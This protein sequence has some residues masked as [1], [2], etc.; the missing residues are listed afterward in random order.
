[1]G[2]N[3]TLR[4]WA[5]SLAI[6]GVAAVFAAPPVA[7]EP[8]PTPAASSV[9]P[10]G[11]VQAPLL[12]P[13]KHQRP[14]STH[15][16]QFLGLN[17]AAL[18]KAKLKAAQQTSSPPASPQPASPS[19]NSA[20]LFNGLNAPGL[21]AADQGYQPTPPDSTGAVGPT[22][23][24][25]FVNQLVGVYDRSNLSLLGSTD[26]GSFVAVPSGLATSDPQIQ[27]D[28]QGNRWFYVAVGFTSNLNN[29]YILFGW[30]KTSD[31]SDLAN[32]WC[33][34]GTQTGTNFPDY[35]KL[36][37]DANFVM[38]GV[39]TFDT[40][41][42]DLPF[43]TADV[44]A[45][46]KPPAA[47]S[48]CSTSV[49]TSHFADATHPLK[50]TDGTLAATPV[51]A[52]TVDP[53]ANGYIVSA[54]DPSSGAQSKLM[55][56]HMAAGPALV[57]DGDISVA[58]YTVPPS[59]PQPGTGYLIDS[60]DGRLTQA[61]ANF[62]PSAGAEAVWTQHTVGNSGR[63]MVRWYEILPGSH[64][65]RQAGQVSSTTDFIW[66]AAI[67][68]S[69]S[70]D[71]AMI[72]Y[73]R[74]SATLL[75]LIGAQTRTKTT[76]L[77]QMD[78]GEVQLA[79]STAATQE[80]LF[81]GNCTS[82]PCRWGDYSSATPDPLNPGVVW[83]SNQVTGQWVFGLAQWQTQNF[84]ITTNGGPPAPPAVPT[85]VTATAISTSQITVA[86][87]PATGATS[88]KIQRSP[89]GSAGWIQVGTSATTSF[90][91]SGLT[92]S[93]TY[94]YRVIAS[95]SVGDS[96][97][98][99]AASATTQAGLPYTQAP[100]GSWVG[101]FGAD[102][103]VLLAWNGSGDLASLTQASLVLDQGGRFQWSAGTSDVRALQS[104]DATT[105]RAATWYDD[106]QVKLRMVFNTAYS[107][108]LHLYAVDWDN[109]AR[110]EN[111]TV[112]DGA[113][114]R[115]ATISSDFTQGAWV[116]APINVGSGGTVTV[117]VT[118]TGGRNAVLSG[119]FLGGAPALPAVPSGVSATAASASQI[120]LAWNA[121]SGAAS[122]R[123]QRSPDGSSGWAQVGT[124]ATTSFSDAG[125][126]P[127]TTYFYRVVA[128]N[129]VGDSPPSAVASATT[130]AG[131]GYTQ[132]PQGTWAGAYG[133]D[134]YA[135]LN[136]NNG[137]D[138]VSLPQ[139]TLTIDQ[140]SRFQWSAATTD[141]RALQ[142][143][144]GSTRRAETIYFDS[145]VRI[146]LVFSS[147]YSGT[148]HVYVVDW[149]ALGRRENVTVNDGSGPRT[150]TISGDFSQGAWINA[151]INVSSGGTVSVVVSRT[152]GVNAVV[153]GLFL[154]GAPGAA[155]PPTGLAATA[156][157]TT[158]ISLTW[159]ASSG[160][161]SYKVQRSADGS[162]GWTQVAAPGGTSYTDSGL[163]PATTYY[164]RVLASNALGDSAPSNVASATTQAS[165]PYAQA[166][167][168]T[169]VGAYGADGYALLN[170][171][172]G[173]DLVS[174]PQSTLAVDQGSRFQWSGATTDVRALQSPDASNR[175]AACLCDG[176][177]VR[178]RMVF[179]SAYSGTLHVYA[180]DF[181]SL[182]RRENITID[183]GSGPR[184][185]TISTDFSQGAWVNAPI[186]V[187]AGGTLL[188]TVTRTAG[189]NSVVSGVFLGAA[190]AT[191]PA[192]SGLSATAVSSSQIN[193]AWT[194]SSGAA[195]YKLQRS[196]NGTSGWTQIAAPATT[197]YSDTGLGPSTA[198]FYRVI[199]TNSVGD[200]APSTVATATTQAGLA[201]T[202]S[203]QGTWVGTYGAS[204][205]ALLNWNNGGDLVSL[206]QCT[207]SIDQGSRFEWSAATTDV[208]ALQ[209]PDGTTRH[210]ETLYFDSEVRIRLV[211]SSA[212]SGTL[213][214]Y[215]VDWDGL[216]RRENVTVNDG[217][218]PRTAAI[219]SDFSQ[220][221]W[222]NAPINVAAGGTVT[223]VISRTAG[224]NAVVSG[225]FLG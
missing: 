36:G 111:V 186:N 134:G 139:S 120:N 73:N 25:E 5:S 183:D 66:N 144:D 84:A 102:G 122:Y 33:R 47:Q 190:P 204:G 32:G 24:L 116:N 68:P 51:P 108:T 200:S 109:L 71:D 42:P 46:P 61:V 115:T 56:W 86:W 113:G 201:Y 23:Y 223:I 6:A 173:G 211:F 11:Q 3:G 161:A 74:G 171:N 93:T 208:R 22:R 145:E 149:D 18:R 210:A 135:L 85:G 97:P 105:R 189:Q 178:L 119:I 99:T 8:A 125:L 96:T 83:G 164:Y 224:V 136:W 64:T 146:R 70:G 133:G 49:T 153:S 221:A 151:P 78:P 176:N 158:Q 199:A 15:S 57:A 197:A 170:W 163:T 168:G 37:H 217:S 137:G 141:V 143:P 53:S 50:N 118:H 172:N 194:A 82:N 30:S 159:N 179:S 165:L 129:A 132:A 138:A 206:P 192:P 13:A 174:L 17:P 45:M 182:G 103:Y 90:T 169:W 19:A 95:N 80:T 175:R 195:S 142:S 150:A 48:T 9:G 107:G 98:S 27:W 112:D 69:I 213:H 38:V 117:T 12:V 214:V 89:D 114:P 55:V 187:A 39:N 106:N 222:I 75:P 21:S 156:I 4:R 40:S 29:S 10:V 101:T 35:P 202:Q 1:M 181:D 81:S 52:N 184:T 14:P 7:A 110:R 212:Y 131:L 2:R 203:P 196:A 92:P 219:S 126:T 26:L 88:Y 67:S 63:S 147:A 180:V 207:M 124:A 28:P 123:V 127:S 104:P 148:L 121:S 167:Q 128:T 20:A 76:A 155:A 100:Q 65:I 225:V 91:D 54:H 60:L 216:G 72:E 177:Q 58:S 215:V 16:K 140:G 130:L 198:Y 77:G 188:I 62:D 43:M 218:G 205:Y 94:F 79:S 209:S 41:K 44:W 162:T 193:L 87:T 220:G 154:G 157:S 34:Y 166:P 59:V 152:A 160:A 191:P 31:P 185:A